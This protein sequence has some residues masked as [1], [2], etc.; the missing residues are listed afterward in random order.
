MILRRKMISAIATIVLITWGCKDKY[1]PDIEYPN[2]G[3]LVVDGF[4]NSGQGNT[5][6]KLSRTVKV[7]DSARIKFENGA[8]VRVE[9]DNNTNYAL[10]PQGNG[11]YTVG[12]LPLNDANK[13]RLYIRTSTGQE[14]RSE[15]SSI[16]RT[17]NI[18]SVSWTREP[19][20]VKI[21]INTHDPNNKTWYYTWSYEETWEYK[22]L[23]LPYLK[24]VPVPP[25]GITV[26][27]INPD[28][29][30]DTT[31]FRCWG[32]NVSSNIL[33]GS[34][35]KLSQD[36]IHLPLIDI[37]EGSLKLTEL[38]SVIMYQHGVSERGYDF[39]QRMK[40]NTEQV[41][42]IFDAQPSELNSNIRNIANPG[43]PVIGFI[44]VANGWEKRIFIYAADVPRWF[45]R[46]E[47]A[48]RV[49][50]NNT[51]SI[52]AYSDRD[53]VVPH[54]VTPSGGIVTFKGA[55]P[56]CIDCRL[57]G[58]KTVKPSFWPQ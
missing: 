6:I 15:F 53:P 38:Y 54:D 37:E 29:S 39:L 7:S 55:Y 42:S 45:Y 22:S 11:V 44:D 30:V 34:S 26:G 33:I 24:Y 46:L 25:G 41:G 16:I 19:S 27:Y 5:N 49:I 8:T 47:C 2:T 14:Y 51:D 13:Y 28:K 50:D 48:E 17:P 32:S 43:E 31:R 4:I 40:K 9:G 36:V 58:G 56:I 1:R 10:T 23:Y 35:K 57:R 52:S 12:Q 3:Y 21:H 18:D 20:G